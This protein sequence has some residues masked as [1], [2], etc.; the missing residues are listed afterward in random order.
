MAPARARIAVAAEQSLYG[1]IGSATLPHEL[2]D[3]AMRASH[4]PASCRAH[5]WRAG[6][7]A[8]SRLASVTAQMSALVDTFANASQHL[9]AVDPE[10]LRAR[11]HPGQHHPSMSIAAA[12]RPGRRGRSDALHRA[13]RVDDRRRD[14]GHPGAERGRARSWRRHE[15]ATPPPL[16]DVWRGACHRDARDPRSHSSS[17]AAGRPLDG[18]IAS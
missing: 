4:E 2:F 11:W 15:E 16:G 12:R 8:I 5:E 14:Q 13:R 6:A 10:P 1:R 3:G 17:S 9:D 7:S 18:D